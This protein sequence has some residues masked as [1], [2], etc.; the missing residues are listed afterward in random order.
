[1]IEAKHLVKDMHFK[2]TAQ[3]I[4]TYYCTHET[5]TLIKIYNISESRKFPPPFPQSIT[6]SIFKM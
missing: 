6:T 2:F 4:F 1:M 3:Y 5:I